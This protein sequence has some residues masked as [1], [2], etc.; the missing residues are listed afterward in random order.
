MGVRA[1][2]TTRIR[3]GSGLEA[4]LC[5]TLQASDMEGFPD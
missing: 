4:K 5:G 2:Q 3:G 1:A